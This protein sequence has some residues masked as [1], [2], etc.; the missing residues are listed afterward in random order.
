MYVKKHY[1][2]F[3][4]EKNHANCQFKIASKKYKFKKHEF[5]QELNRSQ[6]RSK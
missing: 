1:R 5:V 2:I 6:N 3:N 4:W